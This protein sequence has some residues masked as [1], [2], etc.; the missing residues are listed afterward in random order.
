MDIIYIIVVAAV[1]AIDAFVVS[2]SCGMSHSRTDR[3]FCLK[4]SMFFGIAQS[5][6]F[7][8]GYIFGVGLDALLPKLGPWIAFLLL[9][10][11][12]SKM[13][14]ETF[15][16]WKKA[17]EC[18][19]I[20]TRTLVILSIATS[21]DAM[22][23]GVTFAIL[24]NPFIVP[25]IVIGAVTFVLSFSGVLIGDRFRGRFDRYAEVAA[26]VVLVLLAIRVFIE[27]IL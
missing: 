6:L 11:I 1:L 17:K 2:I 21:L 12:G 7:G 23:I 15:R 26:G 16:D 24:G 5:L 27:D 13:I 9:L 20:S 18:R 3:S 4:V 14:L 22:A 25:F 10:A 8:L 19:M